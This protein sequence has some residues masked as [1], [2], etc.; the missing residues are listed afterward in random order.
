VGSRV[1]ARIEYDPII[2]AIQSI[3]LG[4]EASSPNVFVNGSFS[5]RR[6]PPGTA[7]D[8]SNNLLSAGTQLR[9]DRNMLGGTYSFDYDFGRGVMVQ[10][11]IQGYYNAQ[12]CGLII[13][14]QQANY[15]N[16]FNPLLIP[17]DRRFNISFSLGGIGTFSN[18]LGALAGQPTRR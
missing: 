14:F 11:K 12:C 18:F 5:R 9:T 16:L 13:E 10:Q 17:Q 2:S 3:S 6:L 1:N 8:T 4:G 7:P 15:P